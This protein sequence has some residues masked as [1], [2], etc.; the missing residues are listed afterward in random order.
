MGRMK[1]N[2]E[3]LVE[4]NDVRVKR[5]SFLRDISRFRRERKCIIYIGES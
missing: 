4:K 2:T 5:I 3:L 1:S